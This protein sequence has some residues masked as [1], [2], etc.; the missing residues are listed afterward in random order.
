MSKSYPIFLQ[1]NNVK[2]WH[3][4]KRYLDP[5]SQVLDFWYTMKPENEDFTFRLDDLGSG[6]MSRIGSDLSN[7]EWKQLWIDAVKKEMMNL[8]DEGH[9]VQGRKPHLV[10]SSAQKMYLFSTGDSYGHR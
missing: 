2:I 4:M 8:I 6:G 3:R 9:I 1:H 7:K 5:D 10:E